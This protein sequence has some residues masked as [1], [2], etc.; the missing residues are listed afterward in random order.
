MYYPY[1]D[2]SYEAR[3]TLHDRIHRRLK[4]RDLRLIMAMA[5]LGS[6]VKAAARVH[7]TQSAVS[8]AIRELELTLGVRLFDRTPQG[9]EPTKYGRALLRGGVAIFD[10]LRTSVNEIEYLSD[11]TAGE[12]RVGTGD[13]TGF[14]VVPMLVDRFARQY[15]RATFEVVHSDTV[16]L[17][18]HELRGRKVDLAVARVATDRLAEN[19][20]VSALYSDRLRIVAGRES[21]W[22]RR[23]RVALA[24]LV[25]EPW[26]L[27]PAG[28]PITS[29]VTEAFRR[30]GAHPPRRTATVSS[31]QF[32]TNLVARGHFLGVH[33]SMYLHLHPE[34]RSLKVLPVE[35]PRSLPVSVITLKDRTLSPLARLFIE[36]ACEVAK[37]RGKKKS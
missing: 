15:P 7:L 22:A 27:P 12:L 6:M 37:P 24:D 21:V 35:L 34:S 10:D 26:C 33:S 30:A 16:T 13:A 28:H 2:F 11:P 31:A 20:E 5:E 18:E 14:G 23:R 8:R 29:L 36:R 9:V 25:D 19:F 17:L 1:E 3:M 32:V 4:L